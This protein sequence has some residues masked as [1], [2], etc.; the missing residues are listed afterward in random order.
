MMTSIS[1]RRDLEVQ[2]LSVVLAYKN[3]FRLILYSYFGN[4]YTVK[5]EQMQAL[6][7]SRSTYNNNN[8]F[9]QMSKIFKAK[10]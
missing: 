10:D 1:L 6:D 9:A 5:T 2:P 3:K 8:N 4:K 7:W